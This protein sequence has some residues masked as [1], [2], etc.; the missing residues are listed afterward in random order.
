M[1]AEAVSEIGT[2]H[3]DGA[4]A[5]ETKAME[6]S[7]PLVAPSTASKGGGLVHTGAPSTQDKPT[8]AAG[9]AAHTSMAAKEAATGAHA[10]EHAEPLRADKA[11]PRLITPPKEANVPVAASRPFSADTA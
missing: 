3:A 10:P 9:G 6:I 2:R 11:V 7:A 4:A 8:A 5:G 1:R